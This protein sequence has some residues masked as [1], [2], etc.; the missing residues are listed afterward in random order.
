MPDDAA[1]PNVDHLASRVVRWRHLGLLAQ[2]GSARIR[3]DPPSLGSI[4]VTLRT[5]GSTVQIELTVE[6]DSV[7]QLL[8]HHSDRLT[9]SLQ[10]HGLQAAR[11]EINV[12]TPADAPADQQ[13]DT[14]DDG[15]AGRGDDGR[16]GRQTP[17]R[18]RDRTFRQDIE[19]QLN[20]M[21]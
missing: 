17:Q 15:G 1:E 11:I 18:D 20:V 12:Q 9:Q 14:A 6:S 2:G 10:A 5:A 4:D 19:D 7:R 13:G 3:L 16:Q 8:R 21:V